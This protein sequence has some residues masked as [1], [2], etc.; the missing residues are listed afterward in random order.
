MIKY[1]TLL[2]VLLSLSV[3]AKT[4][5]IAPTEALIYPSGFQESVQTESGIIY[6]RFNS[7]ERKSNEVMNTQAGIT[8]EISTKSPAVAFQFERSNHC[9]NPPQFALYRNNELV[10]DHINELTVHGTNKSKKLTNWRVVLPGSCEMVFTGITLTKG[11]KLVQVKAPERQLYLAL[12]DIISIGT[13]ANGGDSH[14]SYPW[15]I[16]D[17]QNYELLNLSTL[18]GIKALPALP[19]VKPAVVTALFGDNNS[20]SIEQQ[21]DS[22]KK[23]ITEICEKYSDSKIYGILQP[24]NCGDKSR[25]DKLREGQRAILLSLQSSSKKL[26]IIDSATF[27]SATDLST[28]HQLNEIGSENLAAA[29]LLKMSGLIAFSK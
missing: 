26:T 4:I 17:A 16:A 14:C 19:S 24:Y 20:L 5:S 12:G 9:K 10:Q 25:C 18:D 22:Y 29:I 8:I 2:I 27:T 6:S 3:S 13:A 23:V 15:H 21:L 11:Y 7:E 28:S 1:I